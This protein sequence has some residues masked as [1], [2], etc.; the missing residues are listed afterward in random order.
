MITL[1]PLP[2]EQKVKWRIDRTSGSSY[3][4]TWYGTELQLK[5]I[6]QAETLFAETS[7]FD[8]GSGGRCTLV[9]SYVNQIGP[10][11]PEVARETQE[12]D[13]EPVQQ[14]ILLSP[15]FQALDAR[16]QLLLRKVFENQETYED[17]LLVFGAPAVAGV[18]QG[19][20]N[21]VRYALAVE[22]YNLMI[23]GAESF[24]NYA[25]ALKRTRSVS[26]RYPG[27]LDL[28]SINT[29]WTTAQLV[30]YTGNPTLFE[31]P[32]LTLTA[33]ETVKNLFAGWRMK[34]CRVAD[35]SD[36]SRQMVEEW[37]LAKWSRRLYALKT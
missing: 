16:E 24:D 13:T 33:D 17:A 10:N 34:G 30:A 19:G 20:I 27:E 11:D 29:L 36:G 7:E 3:R 23:M 1:G 37:Q 35:V 4:R 21:P 22:A 32:S 25:F 28:T 6:A 15:A 8:P 2:Q 5:L 26:R 12:I 9:C 18:T 14:S 31:V